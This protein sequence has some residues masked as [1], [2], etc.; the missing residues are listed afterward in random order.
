MISLGTYQAFFDCTC[1][2]ALAVFM[3]MLIRDVDDKELLN[4]FIRTIA[5]IVS[6]TLMYFV[7]LKISLA[8]HDTELGTY[9][10]ASSLSFA[11]II[12]NIPDTIG[13]TISYFRRYFFEVLFRWNRLQEQ[14]AFLILI[15][16][17]AIGTLILGT[18]LTF[19]KNKINGILFLICGLLMP[20]ATN[21]VLFMATESYV[22]IQMTAGLSFF[23]P[24]CMAI[25]YEV[26]E[27]AH[28]HKEKSAKYLTTLLGVICSVIIYGNYISTQIDQQAN[29]EGKAGTVTIAREIMETLFY[30]GFADRG[31]SVCFVGA[32]CGNERFMYS[33]L[34]PMANDLMQ[35]GNW[36]EATSSTHTQTWVG[37]YREYLGYYIQP[38]Q[39]EEYDT[40]TARDDVA[41]MPMFPRAGSIRE[42]DGV[43]VVKISNNY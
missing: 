1:L 38:C 16:A 36:K 17:V 21:V 18:I 14:K 8:I 24:M 19:K 20:V 42:I 31:G 27:N 39:P 12:K 10:S 32:P 23:L 34:Y 43:T 41:A 11:G 2:V 15:S 35:F 28:F 5:V 22:S 9:N 40:I 33:E 7:G 25:A 6:G 4:F 30:T 3:V 13:K 26:I 29:Y 37:V